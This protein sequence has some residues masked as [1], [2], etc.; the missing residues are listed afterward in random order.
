MLTQ[1][2]SHA[3]KQLRSLEKVRKEE[4]NQLLGNGWEM[5]RIIVDSGVSET[6]MPRDLCPMI[7]IRE[8]PGSRDTGHGP[9][10]Y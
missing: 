7:K 3:D 4:I 9:Q 1:K 6:V 5:I 2:N 10:E 8:S